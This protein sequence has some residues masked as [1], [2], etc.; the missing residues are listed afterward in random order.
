MFL[1]PPT[2]S[3]LSPEDTEDLPRFWLRVAS[4]RSPN[5]KPNQNRARANH[6]KIEMN[7]WHPKR[8]TELL[9]YICDRWFS[10]YDT[11][12]N[13]AAAGVTVTLFH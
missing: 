11:I 9:Y 8:I 12:S 13:L 3:D 1:L 2:R 6:E 10:S 4:V 5:G 7:E